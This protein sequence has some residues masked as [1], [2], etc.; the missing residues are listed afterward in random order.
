MSTT[1]FIQNAR[2]SPR[3]TYKNE[4]EG[5]EQWI[6]TNGRKK[7]FLPFEE[8]K[9]I[10]HKYQLRSFEEWIMFC[11][12]GRRPN[13]IPFMPKEVYVDCWI[14]WGDWLGYSSRA[15]GNLPGFIYVVRQ[16][17]LP[18]NV[19]KIGRTY[20]LDKR[21]Y[22]HE[23]TNNNNFEIIITLYVENMKVA[24]EQAHK[25]A[26]EYGYHYD[27]FNAKEYFALNDIDSLLQQ[28]STTFS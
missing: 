6:G 7:E 2:T 9:G 24:E 16:N 20:R 1:K 19:Y 21:L 4:W 28:L 22:E 23:R 8:A 26:L 5:W 14:S 27:Y 15:N 13:N 17:N 11:K 3:I 10:I 18:Q 25:L 12:Q